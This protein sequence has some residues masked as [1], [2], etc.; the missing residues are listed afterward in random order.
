MDIQEALKIMG[1][2]ANATDPEAG[3]ALE[4]DS[5]RRKRA[6]SKH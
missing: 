4:A 3:E 2:L 6:L 5:I 1:A